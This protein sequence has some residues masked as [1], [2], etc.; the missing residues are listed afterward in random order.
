MRGDEPSASLLRRARSIF[1]YMVDTDRVSVRYFGAE[2]GRKSS[3]TRSVRSQGPE[4]RTEHLSLSIR[5]TTCTISPTVGDT[6]MRQGLEKFPNAGD[7]SYQ[8]GIKYRKQVVSM[9]EFVK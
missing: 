4:C 5:G 9:E 3:G 7:R 6:S 1:L 8:L 2:E